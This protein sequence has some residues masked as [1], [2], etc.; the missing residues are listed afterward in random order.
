MYFVVELNEYEGFV[1]E[2]NSATATREKAIKLPEMFHVGRSILDL[3]NGRLV[4][5]TGGGWNA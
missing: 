5:E 2:K 1:T 4:E 3:K